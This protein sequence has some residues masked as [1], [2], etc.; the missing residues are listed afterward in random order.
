MGWDRSCLYAP[1][2]LSRQSSTASQVR[3]YENTQHRYRSPPGPDCRRWMVEKIPAVRATQLIASCTIPKLNLLSSQSTIET[4]GA[5][6]PDSTSKGRKRFRIERINL[7]HH[8]DLRILRDSLSHRFIPSVV[9]LFITSNC[10]YSRR[11]VRIKAWR[12]ASKQGRHCVCCVYQ[13]LFD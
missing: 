5:H 11:A 13:Y 7:R 4:P 1:R 9:H 6:L 10:Q 2:R 12:T 3:T 8:H